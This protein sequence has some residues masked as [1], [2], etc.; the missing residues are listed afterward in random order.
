MPE[1]DTVHTL[2]NAL[3]PRLEGRRVATVKLSDGT[4]IADAK[5]ESVRALGKHLLFT[6]SDGQ[7]EPGHAL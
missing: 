3:K 2:A 1:G 4:V 6:L 5:V 7:P